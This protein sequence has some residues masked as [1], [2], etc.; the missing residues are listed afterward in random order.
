[1]VDVAFLGTGLMGAPMARNLT[2]AGHRVRAWNRSADKA[3]AL[4]GDGI[5]VA[6]SVGDAVKGAGLVVSMVSDGRITA[7]LIAQAET[8]G[9]LGKGA[10]WV[11]MSSTRPADARAAAERLAAKGVDFVDAPVSGGTKGA[12]AGTLAIMAGGS[13]EA[14]A[15]VEATL[16]AMGR[17]VHVGPVGA[18]Q[19]AKLANQAI[20]AI[21]IGAVAEAM[22]LLERGGAD[23]AKVRAALK[24]GFADGTILQQ[25]GNRMTTRN[26]EP[27]GPSHLQVKDLDNVLE[28]AAEVGLTLPMTLDMRARFA[29]YVDDLGGAER[30]HSGL[31]EE[32]LDLNG[33]N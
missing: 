21:T 19:L 11:D 1:M 6:A 13:P 24:G 7:D 20:V 30:D 18:G 32:L 15:K 2:R 33:L 31:F 29:R 14:F 5:G 12:E 17:P 16:A 9:A 25:H 10:V 22:L 3:H 8:A 23:P 28:V 26:F 4:Q 27:G